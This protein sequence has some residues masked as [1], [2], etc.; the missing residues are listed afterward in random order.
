V[1]RVAFV[2]IRVISLNMTLV[3][4]AAIVL[5]P[6]TNSNDLKHH[7]R[8]FIKTTRDQYSRPREYSRNYDQKGGNYNNIGP[9][10]GTK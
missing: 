2:F 3:L 8:T 4:L 7:K 6:S 10:V 1:S 9:S 5:S